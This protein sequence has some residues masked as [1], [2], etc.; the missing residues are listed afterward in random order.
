MSEAVNSY[1]GSE[2]AIDKRVLLGGLRSLPSRD[3][4]ERDRFRPKA[5]PIV[6][7]A[8]ASSDPDLVNEAVYLI[9][10]DEFLMTAPVRAA[11]SALIAQENLSPEPL[12]TARGLVQD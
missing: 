3:Q 5:Q 12:A 2:K 10:D 7:D 9:R 1:W 4:A 11:L 6:L 8:L